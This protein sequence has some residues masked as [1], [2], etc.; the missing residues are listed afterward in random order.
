MMAAHPK[1]RPRHHYTL[2]EYFALERVG[3]ARY[4]YWDGDIL[5]MSGGSERYYIISENLLTRLAQA[6]EGRD[7]RAFS[8]GAPI[9]TPSLPPYR[10]PDA[11]VVCGKPVFASISGID[12]LTN[13][14][15]IVEVLS[16]STEHLDRE[17]KRKAYQKIASAR[18]Y[19]IVS[20]NAPHITQY[21]RQ[22]RRWMRKDFGDLIGSL[23]LISIDSQVLISDIYEGITFD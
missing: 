2:E 3:E 8:G 14:S 7:C 21:L 1:D 23:E 22:G 15:I 18:E 17:E 5:C 6:S 20:Q 9:Q 11:S 13:P 16:P 12:V 10:Y 19:L 4:E